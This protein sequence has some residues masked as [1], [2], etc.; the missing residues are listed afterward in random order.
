LALLSLLPSGAGG[1]IRGMV[2]YGCPQRAQMV[3]LEE[4][5]LT[6]KQ[7]G[8]EK[9]KSLPLWFL[10]KLIYST[11]IGLLFALKTA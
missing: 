3:M 6:G 11:P 2:V 4:L 5:C 10:N 9:N 1:E 7:S 8:Y